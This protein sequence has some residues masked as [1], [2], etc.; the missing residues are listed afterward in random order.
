MRAD[1]RS[2]ATALI[3]GFLAAALAGCTNTY[4]GRWIV[5]NWSGI[6]DYRHFPSRVVERAAERFDFATPGAAVRLAVDVEV[7]GCEG[8]GPRRARPQDGHDGAARHPGGH[9]ALRGLLQRLRPL[10]D[11]H[12]VLG[13]ESDHI[14]A[15]RDGDR[16]RLHRQRARSRHT[17]C[18]RAGRARCSLHAP[19]TGASAG[20]AFGAALA[21]VGF[22]R[23]PGEQWVYNSSNPILLGIVLERSTGRTVADY[24]GERCGP[25]GLEVYRPRQVCY[26]REALRRE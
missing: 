24:L 7:F 22:T 19:H 21:E 12:V 18:A 25:A 23:E 2:S 11:Q 9:V 10:V 14:T 1:L 15:R 26:R 17:L 3:I 5:W 8:A 6:D 13:S 20:H 4:T 16:R